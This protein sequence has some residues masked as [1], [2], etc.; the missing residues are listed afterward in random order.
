MTIRGLFVSLGATVMGSLGGCKAGEVGSAIATSIVVLVLVIVA[1][2][3]LE[4][5]S[6]DH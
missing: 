5:K 3:V 6:N 2:A 4:R 1:F